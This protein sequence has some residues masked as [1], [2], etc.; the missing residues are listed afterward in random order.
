MWYQMADDATILREQYNKSSKET[1]FFN[2][3]I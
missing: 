2:A 3:N 1:K